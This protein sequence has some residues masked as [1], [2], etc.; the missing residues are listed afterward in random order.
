VL[1]ETRIEIAG[2]VLQVLSP[3][4]VWGFAGDSSYRR[5][6]TLEEPDVRLR[7]VRREASGL[8]F[9]DKDKIFESGRANLPAHV[10]WQLYRQENRFIVHSPAGAAHHFPWHT[11]LLANDFRSGVVYV[12]EDA[13]RCEDTYPLCCSLDRILF[14]NLLARESG[15]LVHSCG[16]A[17]DG[18]GSLF[19]GRSGAGKSTLARLWLDSGQGTVLNDELIVL[20]EVGGRI[21]MFGTPWH[22]EVD[23]CS[24]LGVPLRKVYFLG[25][26]SANQVTEKLPV[27]AVRDLLTESLL[28]FHDPVGMKRTLD[29]CVRLTQEV[30]CYD[31]QFAPGRPVVDYLRRLEARESS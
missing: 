26:G 10:S 29:F 13:E 22:G 7:V 1:S 15:L 25:H 9:S 21:W 2:T 30:P 23:A 20:R 31:L 5:F 28:A 17:I 8:G 19:V 4:Y 11:A 6:L 3:D 14:I 12:H 24:P 18:S 27:P 16:V